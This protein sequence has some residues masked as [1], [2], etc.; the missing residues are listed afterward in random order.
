[1]REAWT[2][3]LVGKMHVNEVSI[4]ELAAEM[5]CTKNYAGMCLNG[6]RKPEGIQERMEN[7]F[8]R[9]ME[10]RLKDLF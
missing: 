10:K 9:V 5:N 8:E 3:E 7:A 1:M 6:H 2:G 4:K